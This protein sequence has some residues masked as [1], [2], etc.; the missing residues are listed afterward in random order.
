MESNNSDI[1]L[2]WSEAYT[3][4]RMVIRCEKLKITIEPNTQK[5]VNVSKR[6]PERLSE[7]VNQTPPE[8][9]AK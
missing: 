4:K 7:N 2:I 8:S 5:Y 6:N 3:G 9:K 1:R